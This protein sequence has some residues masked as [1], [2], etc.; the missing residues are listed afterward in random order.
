MKKYRI[1]TD[2]P[3]IG[4][5]IV[6]GEADTLQQAIEFSWRLGSNAYVL[7]VSSDLMRVSLGK[8]S[9]WIDDHGREH[10]ASEAR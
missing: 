9:Y 8:R 7:H 3:A 2:D 4:A 1:Q 5:P 6:H 10:P